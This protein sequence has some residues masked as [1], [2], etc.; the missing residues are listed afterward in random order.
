MPERLGRTGAA[1]TLNVYGHLFPEPEERIRVAV[2]QAFG[3]LTG[4]CAPKGLSQPGD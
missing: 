4:E 3:A 2:D 1:M